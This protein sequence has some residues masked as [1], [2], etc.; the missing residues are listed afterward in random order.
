MSQ[1]IFR[2][3]YHYGKFIFGFGHLGKLRKTL[4]QI[5]SN[6]KITH[7]H[8]PVFITSSKAC[9]Y[10][11]RPVRRT[12]HRILRTAQQPGAFTTRWDRPIHFHSSPI[13]FSFSIILV[14]WILCSR[15]L[16]VDCTPKLN[17]GSWTLAPVQNSL[18]VCTKTCFSGNWPL[19]CHKGLWYQY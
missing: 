3:K 14:S 16:R 19:W 2:T 9:W 5:V 11:Y 12:E 4:L 8:H 6:N 7:H 1:T 18:N 10:L 15:T 17:S 13:R